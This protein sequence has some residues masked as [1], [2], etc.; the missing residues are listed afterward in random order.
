[1]NRLVN[2]VNIEANCCIKE[3]LIY[4]NVN[5]LENTEIEK[6]IIADNCYIKK[7]VILKGKENKP[8]ILGSHVHVNENIKL[9]SNLDNSTSICHHEVVK[10]DIK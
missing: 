4:N 3:S 1:M 6:A 5:I 2:D 9:I 7:N 10:Q 8:V